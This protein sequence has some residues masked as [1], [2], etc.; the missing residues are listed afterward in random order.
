[1]TILVDDNPLGYVELDQ[2]SQSLI[3]NSDAPTSTEIQHFKM[4]EALDILHHL[5]NNP[6]AKWKSQEQLGLMVESLLAERNVLAILPTGGG[7]S[8][9]WE[10]P[11][12][13]DPLMLSIVFSPFVSLLQDQLRRAK[14]LGIKADIWNPLKKTSMHLTLLFVSWEY[15]NNPK[16]LEYVAIPL[17]S[18]HD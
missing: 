12:Q 13:K 3:T 1:M 14:D 9:C 18:C 17:H 7:K 5:T 6:S 11:A 15:A 4:I 16:L 2:D 10:G 8:A